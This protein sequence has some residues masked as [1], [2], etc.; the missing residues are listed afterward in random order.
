MQGTTLHV[1]WLSIFAREL[2]PEHTPLCEVTSSTRFI[3]CPYLKNIHA[4]DGVE[5][6]PLG[7]EFVLDKLVIVLTFVN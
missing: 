7:N 3:C 6:E 4:G 2:K 5:D 1:L